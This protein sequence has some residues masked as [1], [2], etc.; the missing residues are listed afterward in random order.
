M[1]RINVGKFNEECDGYGPCS[2]GACILM[3]ELTVLC[4]G[5]GGMT[6]CDSYYEENRV[7]GEVKDCIYVR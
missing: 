4:M 6:N 2:L 7:L 1:S 3:W 5:W